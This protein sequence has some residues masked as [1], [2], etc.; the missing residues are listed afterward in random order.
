MSLRARRSDRSSLLTETGTLPLAIVGIVLP[1]LAIFAPLGTTPLLIV[2]ALATVVLARRQLLNRLVK[3]AIPAALL[4]ALGL[5][6][7]ISSQWSII[8]GHSLTESLRFLGIST[9]GMI[10]LA[11]AR[12][13][14]DSERCLVSRAL[15]AGVIIAVGILAIERFGGT[16]LMRFWHP[17][18]SQSLSDRVLVYYR[19]DRGVT[20]LVLALWPA[21]FSAAPRWLRLALLAAAVTMTSL[22][23]SDTSLLA[24]SAGLVVFVAARFFARTVAVLMILT[25]AMLSI[26]IPLATPSYQTVAALHAEAPAIKWSGIHRLLIWRFASDRVAERPLLGW[27]MDSS[28]AIPGGNTDLVTLLPPGQY[29]AQAQAL[30]LHPHN[31][32]LQLRLELGR[33]GVVARPSLF[34]TWIIIAITWR[35]H[36][37]NLAVAPARWLSL[38]R[39]SP[40]VCSASAFG[41]NGGNQHFG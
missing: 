19:Y 17:V 18:P 4:A 40:L 32:S 6:G 9:C 39:A 29:P 25:L 20:V 28:R 23:I 5:W 12:D 8:P 1:P 30:P 15:L 38:H 27:G 35:A 14:G 34:V 21:L 7:A 33:A 26:A 41:R 24:L 11:G 2:A 10:V 37:L 3:L 13:L 31:G 16:P 22:M 36:R